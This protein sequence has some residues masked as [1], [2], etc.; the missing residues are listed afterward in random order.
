MRDVLLHALPYMCSVPMHSMHSNYD[1]MMLERLIV[2]L[3]L[4]AKFTDVQYTMASMY[5]NYE[6]AT[7]CQGVLVSS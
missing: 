3:I 7:T 2:A 6:S 5:S 1:L 4:V